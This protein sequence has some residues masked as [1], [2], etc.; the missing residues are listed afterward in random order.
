MGQ[1]ARVLPFL[2]PFLPVGSGTA[3]RNSL[4]SHLLAACLEGPV[5]QESLKL[6]ES[7]ALLAT[8]GIARKMLEMGKS[9]LPLLLEPG[10]FRACK[11]V[12]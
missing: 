9:G 4:I 1:L 5:H 7:P 3:K 6:G 12:I 11:G 2:V 8:S 10:R